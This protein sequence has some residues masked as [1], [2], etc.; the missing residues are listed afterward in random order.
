MKK[1]A[2]SLLLALV[3][4]LSL[5]PAAAWAGEGEPATL[6]VAIADCVSVGTYSQDAYPAYLYESAVSDAVQVAF[7]DF[8]QTM[9]GGMIASMIGNDYVADTHIAPLSGGYAMDAGDEDWAFSAPYD[10][11]DF[12]GCKAYWLMD[13]NYD[14][15]YFI[16]RQPAADPFEGK[17]F[18]ADNGSVGQAEPEGYTY[19]DGTGTPTSAALY[20][21]TV[22]YGTQQVTLTFAES[23]VAYAYKADGTYIAACGPGGDY[24][25]SGQTGAAA[26][27]IKAGADG[28]MPAFVRVQTPYD[29]QWNSTTLYGVSFAYTHSFTASVSGTDLTDI[30]Y[31][32]DA[33]RYHDYYSGKT[34]QAAVYTVTVPRDTQQVHLQF[35]HNALA[36]N[37]TP[38]GEYV[39][40]AAGKTNAWYADSTVGSDTADVYVDADSDGVMDMIQ[41]Q[42]VY[43]ADWSGGE[44]LYAVTFK[45]AGG[46]SGGS[47]A[48]GTVS[49]G[50]LMD[51]IA[52][53]YAD[54]TGEW[55]VMDMGAYAAYAPAGSPALSAAAKQTYVNAAIKTLSSAAVSDTAYDKAI[56]ALT[57]SGYD[58][59]KLYPVNSNTPLDAVAGL[60][61]AKQSA[62]AWSAPYTLA[63]YHNYGGCPE[64]EQILID[65][66]LA[67]Q[68]DDGSWNEYGTTLDTTANAVCGLSFY[69]SRSEVKESLDKA[70]A[71][72]SGQQAD[73]GVFGGN[74]NSTAL[75]ILALAAQGID[76]DTDSRFCKDGHSALDGLL[77]F[78]LGDNSGFGY[79]NNTAKNALS[80]EQGF[81]ALVA[82]AQVISTGKA[83]NVYDFT[84]KTLT[85]ARA[86][87]TAAVTAPE[88]PTGDKITV[89][90]TIK[91]DTGYWLNGYRLTIPGTDATVYHALVKACADKGITCVG[92]AQ[93][94]VRSM[95]R[96]GVKLGE[97]DRGPNSGWLYKV[98]DTLPDQGLTAYA[99]K[100]GDRIVWYYTDDWTKDP[101]ASAGVSAAT[102]ESG[103]AEKTAQTIPAAAGVS[104][105][106]TQALADAARYYERLGTPAVGSTGG[107]WALIA[108]ARGGMTLDREAYFRSAASFVAANC[109]GQGRLDAG[110]STENARLVL[111]L[112]AIGADVTNVEGYNLLQG[113]SDL[114][115]V[116]KQGLNGPIW[117]LL[118]LDSH[119]YAIPAVS[120][121]GRQTTRRAL[122]QTILDA[123]LTAGGWAISGD[124]LDA[125]MTAMALQALARYRETGLPAE[126]AETVAAPDNPVRAAVDKAVA[127]LSAAQHS[128]GTFDSWGT[129]NCESC[130]QVVT[131]LCA[132]GIDAD[133]DSRF[134]KGTGNTARSALDGLLSFTVAGGGFR[135]TAGG[136]ADD[137]ASE[138]GGCALTAYERFL[139]GKTWL[140]DMSDVAPTVTDT[141]VLPGSATDAP[142]SPQAQSAGVPVVLW[143]LLG[144]AA[145]AAAAVIVLRRRKK[146]GAAR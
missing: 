118:A 18:Y 44:L 54:S 123:Q 86:T 53:S 73:T 42:K 28:L 2:V 144:V 120:E 31:A 90:V 38:D 40:A 130:A 102:D 141:A 143:V 110:K 55:M 65:A 5:L 23:R 88:E 114:D 14:T 126:G 117:A 81:R 19:T 146:D 80:T 10:T 145:I 16:I 109:D 107:E 58:A 76:P 6:S 99:I 113:L 134:I 26:A 70:V 79:K 21:V 89:T 72:L 3:L 129:V 62:S 30:T 101:S 49:F 4:A 108:M 91:S 25:D 75:V 57:A 15:Y 97:F 78:A 8:A 74:A 132:L 136:G 59:A 128:D 82:A 95:T 71:Y 94:Y 112:S 137:M 46:G 66:L 105:V 68:K 47:S 56:L 22:P 140:Y 1:R 133:T 96:G 52:A 127:A 36:Y 69:Q 142:A 9:S 50:T 11:C 29:A 48:G 138:Q 39:V 13:E 116:C 7:T 83:Y 63:V 124:T 32:P 51:S 139:A 45:A 121:G 17:P 60:S 64:K 135:H 119:S 131:A 12:S 61:A 33:Y 106:L 100:N 84:D 34:V 122:V 111:A 41:V 92:A 43:H 85:P 77:S 37:Y 87:G 103:G 20:T 24:A 98:N 35:S 115:F 67:S 93:G 104:T 125:D 27:V